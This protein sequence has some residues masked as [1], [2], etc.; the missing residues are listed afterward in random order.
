MYFYNVLQGA[1]AVG[2]DADIVV[3]DGNATRTISAKTHYQVQPSYHNPLTLKHM[4]SS[5]VGC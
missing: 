2:S 5:S 1:I 3:W 4:P